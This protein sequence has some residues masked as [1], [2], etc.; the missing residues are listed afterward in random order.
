MLMIQIC[1]LHQNF[2]GPIH[3]WRES[4]LEESFALQLHLN[5][6]YSEVRKLP[7]RYRR[8]FLDRLVRHFKEKNE[9]TEKAKN[10]A[11]NSLGDENNSNI[12]AFNK[13]QAL[14]DKKFS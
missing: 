2:F 1:L 5:M 12:D 14:L 3:N 11:S 9:A 13:Y 8:W 6:S 4:F 7:T 10:N